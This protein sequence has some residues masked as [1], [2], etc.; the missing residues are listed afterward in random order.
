MF[1]LQYNES[2][3]TTLKSLVLER[4][5]S[6]SPGEGKNFHFSMLFRPALGSTQ[7]PIQWV[8]GGF[9]PDVKQPAH[10]VD[11]SPPTSVEVK[12]MWVYTPT[13]PYTHDLSLKNEMK[14]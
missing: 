12:K 13:P 1:A 10:E 3:L 4:G 6:S 9:S 7:P 8:P 11:H 2:T 5:Q 14:L